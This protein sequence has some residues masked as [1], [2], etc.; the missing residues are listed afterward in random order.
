VSGVLVE[1]LAA[2]RGLSCVSQELV[3]WGNETLL[4]DCFSVITRAGSRWDR[5]NVVVENVDFT[6]VEIELAKRLSTQYAPSCSEVR[7]TCDEP[8]TTARQHAHALALL[9]QDE[10]ERARRMLL[11]R[12]QR[13]IDPEALNDLAV[14]TLRCGDREA[15]LDLLRALV[16]LHPADTAAAQN[17]AAL[18]SSAAERT[19]P[20]S[21]G[22]PPESGVPD[23]G[24]VAV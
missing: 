22:E 16:R 13:V 23:A 3:A 11:H 8:H 14:L 12:L 21:G 2:A 10:P 9:D 5:G 17:L 20:T 18:I 6:R 4:N 15:A 24:D 7:F 1:Q 19:S